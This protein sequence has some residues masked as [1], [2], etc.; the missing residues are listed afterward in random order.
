MTAKKVKLPESQRSHIIFFH[1]EVLQ[2]NGERI[3]KTS[4]EPEIVAQGVTVGTRVCYRFSDS[5]PVTSKYLALVVKV[6]SGEGFIITA[7]FTERVKRSRI[8]WKKT[9]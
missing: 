2:E 6:F 8:I 9:K 7:Y 3:T 4:L 1:P 5:T